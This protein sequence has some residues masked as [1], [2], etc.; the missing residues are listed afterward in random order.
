MSERIG[1]IAELGFGRVGTLVATL[2]HEADFDV[3]GFNRHA[4]HLCVTQLVMTCT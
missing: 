4:L 3:T 1:H 2:L